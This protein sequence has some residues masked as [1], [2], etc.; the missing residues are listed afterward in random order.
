M[1]KLKK[2]PEYIRQKFFTV[3]DIIQKYRRTRYMQS[4]RKRL[5]NKDFTLISNNCNG[6]VV[7]HDLG[8]RFNSPTINLAIPFGDY[9]KYLQKFEYYNSLELEFV[10]NTEKSY[11]VGK[12][13]DVRLLFVHYKTQQ[14]AK[15]KWENRKKRINKENIFVIFTEQKGCTY[16]N[17]KDFDKLPY[18]N[19]VVF[20]SNKYDDIKSAIFIKENKDPEEGVVSFFDFLN[21]FT[22]KRKYDV[23]DWVS[24]FNGER[25]L[26]KLDLQK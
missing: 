21:H 24:W 11:P 13:E 7:S 5:N 1:K 15:E 25:D 9:V 12:L 18:D 14:E 4:F 3:C 17:L 20:T 6:G 8:L 23:F 19:K 16:Q 22:K 10:E 26:K 2:L